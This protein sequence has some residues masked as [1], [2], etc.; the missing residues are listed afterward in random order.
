MQRDQYKFT[1]LLT[2]EQAKTL[3]TV[4]KKLEAECNTKVTP[5]L[6]VQAILEDAL[7]QLNPLLES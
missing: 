4:A 2:E 5:G 3:E 7:A 1:L 6:L